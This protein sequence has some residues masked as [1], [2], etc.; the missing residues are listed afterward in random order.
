[1]L[2]KN[3]FWKILSGPLLALLTLSLLFAA[4]EI[5]SRIFLEKPMSV[6]LV[7]EPDET[8]EAFQPRDSVTDSRP[9]PLYLYTPE[10]IRLRPD[11]NLLIRRHSHSKKTIMIRTNS[12]GFRHSELGEKEK[13]EKR[14][15]VLGDSI[16]FGDYLS[17]EDTYPY[18]I[19]AYLRQHWPDPA[20][21]EKIH[22]INAGVGAIGLKTELA[23]LLDTGLKADPD[24]VVVGLYLN[25]ASESIHL[26][27]VQFPG[28]FA[29]SWFLNFVAQRL[30]LLPQRFQ[31]KEKERDSAVE[32]KKFREENEIAEKACQGLSIP[33]FNAEI[34]QAFWDWGYA[35]SGPA[36]SEIEEVLTVMKKVTEERGI[37]LV[38]VALPVLFQV[39]GEFYRDD[40]Q[41][42]FGEIAERLKIPYLDLLPALRENRGGGDARFLYYDHCHMTPK[43]NEIAGR[44]IARLLMQSEALKRTFGR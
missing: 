28:I 22:V 1:M 32:L 29:R 43:G 37:E 33:C 16:T 11:M 15:L 23:I 35:W 9:D 31:F 18:R 26:N 3:I 6:S 21:A 20:E 30:G 8:G 39:Y 27:L 34:A 38:V 5:L 19:E 17:R 7:S 41:K 12:L 40:P 44:E 36:Q 42:K 10:G 14:V 25:D 13:G 4:A 2:K 24:V